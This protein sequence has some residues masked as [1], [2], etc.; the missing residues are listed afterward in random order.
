[1]PP[2]QTFQAGNREVILLE[3]EVRPRATGSSSLVFLD[4]P[5]LRE[6]T[7]A[8]GTILG[9]DYLPGRVSSGSAGTGPSLSQFS[10]NASG[11]V[12]MT[13]SAPSGVSVRVES[14]SDLMNWSPE[15]VLAVPN[16]QVVFTG[17]PRPGATSRFYRAV[18][19]P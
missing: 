3:F 15:S 7:D 17:T 2:G 12:Q 16:G 1:L 14:S 19:L 4:A 8:A 10:V 13:I 11:A 6:V 9:A 5:I 18:Q